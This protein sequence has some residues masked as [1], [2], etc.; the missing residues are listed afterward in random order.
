MKKITSILM[1]FIILISLFQ[2]AYANEIPNGTKIQLYD[3]YVT[4]PYNQNDIEVE[5]ERTEYEV[6]AIIKDK[7]TGEILDIHG[8]YIP[9][10]SEMPI[11][12]LKELPY[13]ITSK[14]NN[15]EVINT[16]TAGDF[17]TKI[18]YNDK[19]IGPCTGRLYCEA[20]YYSEYN[21]RNFVSIDDTYWREI[22]SGTWVIERETSGAKI[23]D[24]ATVLVWG[25]CNYVVTT[26]ESS[27]GS[28][29]IKFL[30]TLGFTID[31]S[32]G[33]TYYLRN[34][35]DDFRYSYSLY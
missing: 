18:I 24:P 13:E 11:S 28:W 17:F 32:V 14:L 19:T 22:S 15:L 20:T 26:Q 10:L 21:Y 5:Y 6:R 29:S 7:N 3:L 27:T 2:I 33:T 8:E 34:T 30:E 9:S 16:I 12:L 25:G 23:V 4:V 1:V 35:I 31:Y